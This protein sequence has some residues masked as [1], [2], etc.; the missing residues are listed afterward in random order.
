MEKTGKLRI[1]TPTDR[2][3][4]ITRAFDAPRRLVWK[5]M[6]TPELIRRWLF[7]PP[8]WTMTCCEED[9]RVDGAYR[10]EWSDPD[11]NIAM[12][13]GG[14]YREVVP[15]ERLVRTEK[16]EF[17]C[18]PQAGEQ[19][20][21]MEFIEQGGGTLVKI[22]VVYPSKEARDGALASGMEQGMSAGYDKL[23]AML[24]SGDIR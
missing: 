14:V 16:F 23:E 13:M 7:L 10:W 5:A 15:Q 22:T 4:V 11:G 3:I 2:E 18:Q 20:G 24:A 19:L 21:T 1:T 9:V 17:G 6:T 12:A 8:G